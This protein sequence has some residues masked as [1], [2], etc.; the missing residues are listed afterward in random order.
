MTAMTMLKSAAKAALRRVDL[1]LVRV[2]KTGPTGVDLEHDFARLVP[3]ANPLVLDV[4]ANRGQSIEMYLACLDRPTI[5]S[6]EPSTK[7]MDGL[8][9][10]KRQEGVKWD[11]V[12]LHPQAV[13]S[14]AERRT[15]R[16]YENNLLTSLLELEDHPE[17]PF[18]GDRTRVA[19][20]EEVEVT[21]VDE[22]VRAHGIDRVDMLKIDTQGLD[23]EVLKGAEQSIKNGVVRYIFLEMNFVKMYVGQGGATT[24]IDYLDPLGRHL[25]GL[26][27]V[28][29]PLE[30]E[31]IAWASGLF[32]PE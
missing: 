29:R 12:L 8:Q 13:G 24:L 25:I 10:R 32:G 6:F 28:Y 9:Q 30:G 19:S 18:L 21:T 11:S 23:Y 14:Q 3:H 15:L 31:R 1:R 22:F 26:Y 17:N 7:M 2:A 4:G 20:T 16:N 27:E 5:H